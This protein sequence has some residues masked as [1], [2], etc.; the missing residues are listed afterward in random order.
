MMDGKFKEELTQS[1]RRRE[2]EEMETTLKEK[3]GIPIIIEPAVESKIHPK[4][5]IKYTD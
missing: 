5:T 4:I 2:F 3:K 1:T